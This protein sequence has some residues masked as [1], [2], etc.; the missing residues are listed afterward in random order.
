MRSKQLSP[1]TLVLLLLATSVSAAAAPRIEL[2]TAGGDAWTFDHPVHGHVAHGACDSVT[3]QSPAGTTLAVL[4]SD[5]FFALVHL[6]AGANNV[7][8]Q[9]LRGQRMVATSPAQ[10]WQ[11]RLTDAPRAWIRLRVDNSGAVQLDGRHTELA[12]GQPA[13]IVSYEWQP[14]PDDPAPLALGAGERIT[15]TPPPTDGT[16]HV[17]LRVTD[18]LG[19]TDTSTSE[20]RVDH[21]RA[22]E[23]DVEHAHPAWLDGAVLYGLPLPLLNPVGF[24]GVRQRLDSIVA[25]GATAIL[26]SPVTEAPTGDFGYAV[27][28]ELHVRGAFGT[29]AQLRALIASA[30]A[31]R[32]QVIFDVVSNHLAAASGYYKDS[33]QAGARSPYHDWFQRQ[34]SGEVAHYFDWTNLENLNYDNADVRGY[35]TAALTHWVREFHIDG[36]RLDAAWAVRERAPEFWPQLRAELR[37]INPDVMLLMESSARDSYYAARDFDA[38][39]DWTAKLGEWA[40]Q[41]V[42]GE[43]GSSPDLERLRRALA[44]SDTGTRTLTLHF[45]N[46][47]DTGPRFITRHGLQQT[48]DAAALLLT[49]PGLPLIYA[50]DEVG[51]A[52]EPY[53]G[54]PPITWSDPYGLQPSYANLIKLRRMSSALRS[55]TL[56]ILHT[57]QDESVLAFLRQPDAPGRPVLVAI[58]FG[59]TAARVRV[60]QGCPP[61]S[62][63]APASGITVDLQP[64]EFRVVPL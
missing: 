26:L 2:D 44:A 55:G 20:F 22:V 34:S 27:T 9:C 17:T 61:L 52:Y 6:W 25:L 38:V 18:A 31:H 8:A 64:H 39:Y 58:N 10:Q 54:G 56:R 49:L 60:S 40:W 15:I 1:P 21:G 59:A 3:V 29:E 53:G 12:R 45:L 43:P 5:H 51:A 42:F 63:P 50:G 28:D 19:R 41:G 11:L 35:I 57:G 36:F 62:C 46:N 30:H 14:A 4:E 7:R 48:R 16:Y 47:N 23:I 32:L 37:R 13:P 33:E 24:E